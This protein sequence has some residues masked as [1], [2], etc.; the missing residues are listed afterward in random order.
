M[1]CDEV[2]QRLPWFLNGS[3]A[4]EEQSEIRAHLTD[5]AACR[6]ALAETR[7]GYRIFSAHVPSEALV[8]YAWDRTPEGLDSGLV[9]R[10]L[11][12]CAECAAELELI[13]TSRRLAEEPEVALLRPKARPVTATAPPRFYRAWQA[14][15]LAAALGGVVAFSAW[16]H[17]EQQRQQLG[18]QVAS[19][20]QDVAEAQ[21]GLANLT[22]QVG[23][24]REQAAARPLPVTTPVPSEPAGGYGTGSVN[25]LI[26]TA[27]L[28]RGG[29]QE[30]TP[31]LSV[32]SQSAPLIISYDTEGKP[33]ARYQVEVRRGSVP[34][35]SDPARF[36]ENSGGVLFQVNPSR[37]GKGSYTLILSA[38]EGGQ[39]KKI[40]SYRFDVR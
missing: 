20:R 8:D 40:Q 22:A 36:D 29:E 7:I 6:S 34:V 35:F 38:I 19:A 2:V 5:C 24:L 12:D 13:R 25:I 14:T 33:A 39:A 11:E 27:E 23:Q 28:T 26:L 31:S 21:K 32:K 37:L 16:T 18:H 3:L 9:E 10:H 15:A 30:A 17:S 4:P 1:I